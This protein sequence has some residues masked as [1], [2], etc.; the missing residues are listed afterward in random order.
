[1]KRLLTTGLSILALTTLIATSA[2]AETRADSHLMSYNSGIVQP[3]SN[4]V[5]L[6]PF[7]LAF[8]AQ[9]GY[10]SDQGISSYGI[11]ATD[12]RAGR[13]TATD[14]VQAAIKANRLPASTLQNQGYLNALDANVRSFY[15]H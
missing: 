5:S 11:L 14:I 8:L 7:D 6:S 12:Y 15:V 3:S 13:V 1:M 10:L 2:K 9:R 4:D